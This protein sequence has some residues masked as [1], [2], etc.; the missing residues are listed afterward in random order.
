VTAS[1]AAPLIDLR[2]TAE[3][4]AECFNSQTA[5]NQV[6]MMAVHIKATFTKE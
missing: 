6:G 5:G 4:N 1:I 2:G 3:Q